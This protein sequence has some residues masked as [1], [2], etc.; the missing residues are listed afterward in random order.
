MEEAKRILIRADASETIGTGHIMRCLVLAGKLKKH[1]YELLF[2]TRSLRGNLDQKIKDSGFG[3]LSIASVDR[4]EESRAVSKLLK[5]YAAALLVID[6][7]EIDRA[8]E[9]QVKMETGVPIM[10]FDDTY[11]SHACDILLNQNIHADLSRYNGLIPQSCQAFCG[12]SYALIR[13]EFYQAKNNGQAVDTSAYT[14][15]VT[16]GGAD[17]DNVTLQVLKALEGVADPLHLQVVLGAVNPHIDSIRAYAEASNHRVEVIVDTSD[18]A[19]LMKGADMA[20]TAA[21]STTIEALYMGLPSLVVILAANQEPIANFL[22]EKNLAVVLGDA[23][24]LTKEA[25]MDGMEQLRRKDRHDALCKTARL[26]GIGEGMESLM[27]S[28]DS[29]LTRPAR[30]LAATWADRDDLLTLANDKTVRNNSFSQDTI[31]LDRHEAWLKSVLEDPNRLLLVVKESGRFGGQ[32]RF[33][34]LNEETAVISIALNQSLRGRS[35]APSII[36]DAL[37][38][39]PARTTAKRVAAKIKRE[40]SASRRSFEKAGFIVAKDDPQ[41]NFITMEKEI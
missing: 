1:G 14:V 40:N 10:V 20:I 22:R 24:N 31:T 38:M 9:E 13:E 36:R 33:D 29:L 2:L 37:G 5:E 3:C 35:L 27:A 30:L 12:L 32:V 15:L 39:I 41:E 6:H 4:A 28:I 11:E 17:A 16:L 18:M 26:P 19:G 21:G 7:Y 8:Y 25:V 23:G 34:D